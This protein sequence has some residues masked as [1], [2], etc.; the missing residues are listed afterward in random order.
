MI[1]ILYIY[2]LYIF[3]LYYI[4]RPAIYYKTNYI[5]LWNPKKWLTV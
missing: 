3:K 1:Y 5:S 2:Y 4:I